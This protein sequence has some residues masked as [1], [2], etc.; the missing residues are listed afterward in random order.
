VASSYNLTGRSWWSAGATTGRREAHPT[1]FWR[2]IF[3]TGQA[4]PAFRRGRL[5]LDYARRENRPA[6]MLSP[7]NVTEG[8]SS[9]ARPARD[10][11]SAASREVTSASP[12]IRA[13]ERSIRPSG[14]EAMSRRTSNVPTRGLVRSRQLARGRMSSCAGGRTGRRTRPRAPVARLTYSLQL[15]KHDRG[16]VFCGVAW[17]KAVGR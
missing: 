13:R 16:V 12:A 15:V 14:E 5:R 1:P 17:V 3:P 10:P 8:S 6:E 4:D 9:P 7:S 11:R 2:V